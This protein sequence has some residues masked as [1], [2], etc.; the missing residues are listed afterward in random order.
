MLR[1]AGLALFWAAL[2][3]LV[4]ALAG[5]WMVC[6]LG[7][8][9]EGGFNALGHCTATDPPS[10]PFYSFLLIGAVIGGIVGAIAAFRRHVDPK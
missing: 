2:L 9:A 4:L 8:I 3:G 5:T 6:G 1:V 7:W 10:E